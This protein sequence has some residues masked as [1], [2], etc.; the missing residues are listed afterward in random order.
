MA[1]TVKHDLRSE[2]RGSREGEGKGAEGRRQNRRRSVHTEIK[3]IK[4][5]GLPAEALQPLRF[6]RELVR[7]LSLDQ[8]PRANVD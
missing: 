2:A 5:P 4:G 8:T 7:P 1:G 6:L 3:G